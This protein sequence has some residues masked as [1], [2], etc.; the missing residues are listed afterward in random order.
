MSWM[1]LLRPSS[2][3]QRQ[4]HIASTPTAAKSRTPQ[5]KSS[6][7]F[8]PRQLQCRIAA[9]T[10]R[11]F[12][13]S[14]A[15]IHRARFTSTWLTQCCLLVP[16]RCPF[17]KSYAFTH[18]ARFTST[19]LHNV[20]SLSQHGAPSPNRMHSLTKRGSPQPGLHSAVALPLH[21][22][23]CTHSRSKVGWH[24]VAFL[25]QHGAPSPNH[26]HSLTKRGSLQPCWHSVASLSQHSAPSP[27]RMHSLTE[28]GSLQPGWHNVASCPNTVPLHQ[29][30]CTRSQS[31]VHLNLAYIIPLRRPFTNL[32]PLTSR[33]RFT[34]TGP[35]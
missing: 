32:R 12:T 23:A 8:S 30:D 31:K 13:N 1:I 6:S 18:G 29:I 34:S 35:T 26:M 27:N 15:L 22:F 33:A 19:W 3:H 5:Y 11:P 10:Q 24:S 2:V 4:S 17:T 9:P 21:Q 7:T 16:T 25:F 20:A 28:R 14:R